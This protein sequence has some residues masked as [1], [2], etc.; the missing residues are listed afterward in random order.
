MTGRGSPR[1]AA[2]V[3]TVVVVLLAGAG[4]FA[5]WPHAAPPSRGR[6]AAPA[7]GG[8]RP[9]QSAARGRRRGPGGAGGRIGG[10]A[11]RRQLAGPRAAAG[12]AP[13]P[14]PTGAAPAGPLAGVHRALPRRAGRGRPRRGARRAG[15]A[16]Q[17]LGVLV[18]PLPGRAA[19]PRRG[20]RRAPARCPCSTVD[21]ADDP[22]GRARPCSPSSACG[23]PPSPTRTA[24]SRGALRLPPGLPLS[25]VVRADGSVALVDPPV[26]FASADDVA[27][28]VDAPVVRPAPVTPGPVAPERAPAWLR[29]LLDAAP[30]RR[31]A[32][33]CSATTGTPARRRP[34][35]RRA[36]ALRRDPGARPRRAAR[37]AGQHPA[38][39]RGPGRVP[40]RR[41]PTPAIPT[42]SPPPC[43]R[44]R[45]RPASTRPASSRSPC[46]PSSTCRRRASWSPRCW[47][48]GRVRVA[49]HAVDP[50]ETATVVRVPLAALA[51]PANRL[52]VRHPSSGYIG[53]GVHRVGAARVGL[54]GGILS[55]LLDR[56]GWA[57]PWDTDRILDLERG[58]GHAPGPDR[59]E[60]A[61]P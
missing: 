30:R 23:C 51:D 13:C 52:R 43:A 39:P 27:A 2:I 56:G 10:R 28:A 25:Y 19:R 49:V 36:H 57:R 35:R 34:P 32:T 40:R 54:H 60:V 59:Q 41:R 14:A 53:P 26:P 42:R 20:T 61:G 31:R 48:T 18:R 24:P 16:R 15:H 11:A 55:A 44:P 38:R 3:S 5:L 7:S 47:R 33:I 22:R 17:R 37:G 46:C 8:P 1:R 4:V 9:R 12:L 58:V 45:R 21:S 6:H 50:G 29:P